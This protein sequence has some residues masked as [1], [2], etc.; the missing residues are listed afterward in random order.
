MAPCTLVAI[1]T[2]SRFAMSA[3]ARPTYSSLV[4]SEYTLAVSKNVMPASSARRMNVRD[5]SSS[6]DHEWVP[7]PDSPKL[8]QPRQMRDTSRPVSPSLTYFTSGSRA[9]S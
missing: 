2:S 1:T 6:S 8:M 4:P 7:R 3:R 9:G 5:V